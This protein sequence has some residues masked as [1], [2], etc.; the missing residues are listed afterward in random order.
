[1]DHLGKAD[2]IA[3]F[4]QPDTMSPISLL[5]LGLHASHGKLIVCCP[6]G[7][8]RTGNVQMVCLRH[9]IPLVETLEELTETVKQKLE[10]AIKQREHS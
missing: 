5:E 2:V 8:W 1:M 6:E 7:F 3:L 9:G 4:F 10:K